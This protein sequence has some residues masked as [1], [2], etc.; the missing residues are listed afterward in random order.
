M[1]SRPLTTR[2]SNRMGH[3]DANYGQALAEMVRNH[4]RR[5]INLSSARHLCGTAKTLSYSTDPNHRAPQGAPLS[6]R[7]KG[8]FPAVVDAHGGTRI[9]G[10]YVNNDPID[11]RVPGGGIVVMAIDY[12]LPPHGTYPCSVAGMNNAV[13]WLKKNAARYQSRPDR[14]GSM[15]TS[16]GEHLAVLTAIKSSALVTRRY[17]FRAAN[18]CSRIAPL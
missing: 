8:P 16:A 10:T 9:Q 5:A 4:F 13:R 2:P 6:A 17:R 18:E 14:T 7:G 15:R 3:Y 12:T 11:R 1:H